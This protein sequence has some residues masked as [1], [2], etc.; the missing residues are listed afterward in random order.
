[1]NDTYK[2]ILSKL[3]T[4]NDK[5]SLKNKNILLERLKA[6][7]PLVALVDKPLRVRHTHGSKKIKSI[8]NVSEYYDCIKSLQKLTHFPPKYCCKICTHMPYWKVEKNGVYIYNKLYSGEVR[9]LKLAIAF[10]KEESNF[11][12]ACYTINDNNNIIRARDADD[13]YYVALDHEMSI[14]VDVGLF[15]EFFKTDSTSQGLNAVF[16]SV[17]PLQLDVVRAILKD[18]NWSPSVKYKGSILH[19]DV[20]VDGNNSVPDINSIDAINF[21]PSKLGLSMYISYVRTN[22]DNTQLGYGSGIGVVKK[23]LIQE[24]VKNS[25]PSTDPLSIYALSP[26]IVFT[27]TDIDPIPVG[28]YG[29]FQVTFLGNDKNMRII[30]TSEKN[31][32]LVFDGQLHVLFDGK[33]SIPTPTTLP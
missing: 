11:N 10:L 26:T 20:G 13:N 31:G 21:D 6:T 7:P 3:I 2:S 12:L 16:L 4:T 5:L 25:P 1:M 30:S 22:S 9:K 32:E 27:E 23:E 15:R 8:Q 17:F 19:V 29:V 24:V 33:R 18:N 14:C 28:T